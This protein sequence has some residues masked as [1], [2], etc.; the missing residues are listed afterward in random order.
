V[1]RYLSLAYYG[2]SGVLKM[3]VFKYFPP[4]GEGY[5]GIGIVP[6]VT[7]ELSEEARRY[8]SFE[9]LGKS[10]DNQLVEAV[11]YFK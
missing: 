10:V 5:D 1:Q 3:T 9:L 2:I 8:S 7:V 11:K 4:C 6:N